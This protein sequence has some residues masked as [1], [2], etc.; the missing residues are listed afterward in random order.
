MFFA[1]VAHTEDIDAEG[2]LEELTQRCEAELGDRTPQAGILL[3]A[4]EMDHGLILNGVC[5]AWPGIDLIG[6]TTDG[7][8]SSELGFRE[9]SIVL[10]LFGS[11]TIEITAGIGHGVGK[12]ITGAC[13][14][15]VK[16]ATEKTSQTPTLCIALPESM[17]ASG[18]QIVEALNQ[19]LGGGVPVFGASSGDGYQL[20][21]TFQFFGREVSQDSVP[22]LIFSGPLVYSMAVESGWE[23]L[24]EPGLVTRAEGTIV[25]EVDGRPAIEFY[26]RF[27]GP[28][29]VPTPEC[30][31][32]ILD[33]HGNVES[34]R[35]TGGIF[36]ADTGAITYLAEIQEGAMVQ[37]TVADRSAILAGCTASI[38]KAFSTYPHGKVPEAALVFSCAARKLLLGTRTGEEI[39]IIESVIGPDIPVCGFY[40]YGEIGPRGANDQ[41]AKYHN[42]TFVS[43][44]MGT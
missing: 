9:D 13:S 18:Q 19:S 15:A 23:P 29:A 3:S 12:D 17:T 20:I 27:Q 24:G 25:C 44:I 39:G 22:V 14:C 21:Q 10:I 31:L 5:D 16:M 42:E 35:A 8:I 28:D 41:V 30:P 40:G 26:R 38:E 32:A 11:D 37:I 43:L 6:C 2:A 7:E 34:L 4:I 33:E 36:D 1:V